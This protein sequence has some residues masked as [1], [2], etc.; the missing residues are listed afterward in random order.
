MADRYGRKKGLI[1]GFAGIAFS[2]ACSIGAKF[3]CFLISINLI[4]DSFSYQVLNSIFFRVSL[5]VG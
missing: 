3:V 1:I 5:L 2:S 4:S